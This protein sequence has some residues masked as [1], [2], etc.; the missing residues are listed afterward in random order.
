MD[1]I[2]VD[3]RTYA[4]IEANRIERR[5]IAAMAM[6]GFLSSSNLSDL[7][8]SDKVVRN[9]VRMADALLEELKK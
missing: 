3:P 9:A 2:E 4:E 8:S 5:D 6:Q 7:A 1:G